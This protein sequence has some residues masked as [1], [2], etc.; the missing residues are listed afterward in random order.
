L[1]Y[2]A[3]T[4]VLHAILPEINPCCT[5]TLI[6]LLR[7]YLGYRRLATESVAP[8]TVGYSNIASIVVGVIIH[9]GSFHPGG[10][11]IT[12]CKTGFIH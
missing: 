2:T 7:N 6:T 3:S 12:T 4:E 9:K 5:E 10:K 1:T 8:N 11:Q